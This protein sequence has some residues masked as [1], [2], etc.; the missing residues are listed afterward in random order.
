MRSVG[1]KLRILLGA[2]MLLALAGC[3][4]AAIPLP[5][6]LT[7]SVF[8]PPVPITPSG[9]QTAETDRIARQLAAAALPRPEPLIKGAHWHH[10]HVNSVDP[11]ASIA[12]YTKF[13]DAKPAKF[14]GGQDAVWSQKS[15][16]LF[17][18]VNAKASTA[19]N[20]AIWHI[21]WGTPDPKA[22]FKRQKEM[23]NTFQQELTD[24]ATTT[25]GTLDRFYFMYVKS[26]DGT[27]IEL[28]TARSDNFGHMHMFAED[29][30]ATGDWYIRFFG[31]TGRGLSTP[32][33]P[34]RTVRNNTK[35]F[36]TGP[37]SSLY[38]DNVNM[39]IYPANY[40]RVA[41]PE[42]WKGKTELETTRGNVNDHF[43]VSVPD[44]NEALKVFRANS[45][46]VTAE[47]REVKDA[48][49][50]LLLKFAF[51]EG[52]DKVAIELVEDHSEHPPE[53]Q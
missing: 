6:T 34:A 48:S 22:E 29:P 47:P 44:L 38:F 14:A 19:H 39:I 7:P 35:G 53:E 16:L 2:A 4:Q 31:V 3:T 12:Y 33:L 40:S 25:G 23:G 1:V 20:T 21:G 15:W 5:P 11:K 26:P 28:N 10:F 41:Y 9:P 45:V 49:G 32:T 8:E 27:W 37:S 13:F 24:L 18:K 51:I 30:I 42:D 46:K 43:G 17:T 36:Q 50:K 52:P